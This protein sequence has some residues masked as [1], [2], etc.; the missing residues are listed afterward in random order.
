MSGNV[1]VKSSINNSG[2]PTVFT[3]NKQLVETGMLKI[4]NI[5]IFLFA[6]PGF[7]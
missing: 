2:Y 4:S 1:G 7:S 5:S 6:S 3:V